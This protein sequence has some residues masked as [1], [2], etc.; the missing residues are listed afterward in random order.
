MADYLQ[1]PG[2]QVTL[3]EREKI[4][5]LAELV[6][7][8]FE[9]PTLVNL[10]VA[11]GCSMW[12]LRAGAPSAVL[13]GVDIDYASRKIVDEE[14]LCAILIPGDSTKVHVQFNKLVHLLFIDGDHHYET[15]KQDISGWTPKV[16]PGGIVVF[17][18]YAPTELNLRQFP[19][20]AGVRKAVD[21]W[22][23]KS[24]NS[25]TSLPAPDSLKV[26]KCLKRQ[27]TN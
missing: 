20:I 13:Y 21:E 18:D 4:K 10:G 8:K 1:V 14:N 23:N 3:A 27:S 24:K 5:E 19:H 11:W 7:E 2:A 25:W 9:V 6:A 12:C 15:I 22:Y 16:V 26:F 17:H